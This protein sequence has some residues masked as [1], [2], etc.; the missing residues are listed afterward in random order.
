MAIGRRGWH[1][2]ELSDT[3]HQICYFVTDTKTDGFADFERCYLGDGIEISN[4]D[5][6]VPISGAKARLFI[7]QH[8]PLH[9]QSFLASTMLWSG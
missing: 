7:L 2:I 9:W 1:Y 3:Y 8:K 6:W 4:L 5:M